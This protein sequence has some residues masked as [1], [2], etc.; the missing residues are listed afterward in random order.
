[1]LIKAIVKLISNYN[2]APGGVMGVIAIVFFICMFFIGIS[3]I[4]MAVREWIHL[5]QVK[6]WPET[7]GTIIESKTV[8]TTG[9]TT[10]SGYQSTVYSPKILFEFIVDGKE[11]Q[12]DKVTWGGES[13]T[14]IKGV[15]EKKIEEYPVGKEI[16]VHF[17]PQNPRDCIVQEDFSFEMAIPLIGGIAFFLG[18]GG[19]AFGLIFF[20]IKNLTEKGLWP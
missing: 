18:G 12:S 4:I 14:N 20:F 9:N 10:G 2:Q 6:L 13:R 11:Y 17:N 15:I 19:F 8:G 5:G 1:M 3:G 16:N 7:K